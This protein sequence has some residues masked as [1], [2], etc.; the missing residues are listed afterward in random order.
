MSK[1][2]IYLAIPYTGIENQSFKIAN[3][4]AAKLMQ[5]DIIVFSPIS[6][7]HSIS[8]E[9]ELPT[10]WEFWKKQ[11]EEFIKWCDELYVIV[12]HITEEHLLNMMLVD[13][14]TGVNAEIA[15]AKKLNKKRRYLALNSVTLKYEIL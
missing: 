10:S 4:V 2:K 15:I 7:S 8:M 12:P 13:K 14:S 1:K 5:D 6:H 11:D 3:E 9:N